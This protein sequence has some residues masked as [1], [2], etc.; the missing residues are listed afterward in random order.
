MFIYYVIDLVKTV[1]YKLT[2]EES[3]ICN[4]K[5]KENIQNLLDGAKRLLDTENTFQFP[6]G[7]YIYA[8]EE[9]GKTRLLEKCR[10]QKNYTVPGWIFGKDGKTA[11]AEK[12]IEGFSKLPSICKKLGAIEIISNKSDSTLTFRIMNRVEM[13]VPAYLSILKWYF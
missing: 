6:L 1:D 10:E 8:I 12:L 3:L 2:E 11:H 13:S 9:Y 7:L 5:C 4:E